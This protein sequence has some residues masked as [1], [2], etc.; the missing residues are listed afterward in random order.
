MARKKKPNSKSPL[1]YGAI[2]AAVFVCLFYAVAG[3][4]FVWHGNRNQALIG[5]I[6]RAERRLDRLGLERENLQSQVSRLQ[7]DDYL[8]TRLSELGLQEPR[9]EQYLYL[10]EPTSLIDKP[11]GNPPFFA[12]RATGLPAES[13]FGRRKFQP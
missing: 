10:P 3:V 2:V 12:G 13:R 9:I 8:R 4:G 6:R 5:E 7:S 1:Q 11:V